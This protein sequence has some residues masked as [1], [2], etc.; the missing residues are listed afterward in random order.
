[1]VGRRGT[2]RMRR[3]KKAEKIRPTN[4]MPALEHR[5]PARQKERSGRWTPET[6]GKRG[7]RQHEGRADGRRRSRR[8]RPEKEKKAGTQQKKTENSDTHKQRRTPRQT[9]KHTPVIGLEMLIK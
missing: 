6:T 3:K 9:D 7:R 8:K 4:R 1:M 5:E 2:E